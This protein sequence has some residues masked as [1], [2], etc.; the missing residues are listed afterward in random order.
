MC[1]DHSLRVGGG[2][3]GFAETGLIHPNQRE[4]AAEMEVVR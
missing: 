1:S 2:R 4:G 3:M